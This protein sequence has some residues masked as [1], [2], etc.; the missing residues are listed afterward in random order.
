MKEGAELFEKIAPLDKNLAAWHWKEAAQAWIKAKDKPR[1]PEAAK[2]SAAADPALRGEQLLHFWHRAL[3][4]VFLETG[5]ATLAI[6]HLEA[7]IKSTTNE[8]YLKDSKGELATAKEQADKLEA[9]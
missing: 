7:A 9:K 8:G 1:A 2:A 6:E 5:E 3:G 4:Q